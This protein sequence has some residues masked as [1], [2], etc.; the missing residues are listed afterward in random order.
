MSN[1]CCRVGLKS[2]HVVPMIVTA[3]FEQPPRAR[4][5]DLVSR[6]DADYHGMLPFE[7]TKTAG[8]DFSSTQD[9]CCSPKRASLAVAHHDVEDDEFYL[10][11]V[12][13]VENSSEGNVALLG[14]WDH[15]LPHKV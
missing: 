12:S 2:R 7:R 5:S 4:I 13:Q 6:C 1:V 14:V 15:Q 3:R 8:K 11:C 10:W 9:S